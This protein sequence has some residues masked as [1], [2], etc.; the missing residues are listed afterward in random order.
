MAKFLSI[1]V[2]NEGNQLISADDIKIIKQ[3]STTTVT[4]TYG[5]AAAQDVITITHAAVAAGSE[6][7]RDVIQN[8]VVD[9]HSSVWHNVVT[10]V[11]PSKAV[12]AI[13]IA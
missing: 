3:A 10:A 7:M 13:V 9:A 5:G 12:S 8:A 1:P 2:T 6:E 11:S 4:V